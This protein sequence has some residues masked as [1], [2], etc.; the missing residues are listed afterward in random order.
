MHI[1]SRGGGGFEK[2]NDCCVREIRLVWETQFV[3][4]GMVHA[5]VSVCSTGRMIQKNINI[6]RSPTCMSLSQEWRGDWGD[7]SMLW[8]RRRR[9]RLGLVK[10]DQ[11]N[12][13]WMSFNDF[14]VAF[15]SLYVCRWYDPRQ[16]TRVGG[17]GVE[18]RKKGERKKRGDRDR[19]RGRKRWRN[20]LY[21]L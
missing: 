16:D 17:W 6:I 3:R 1:S 18:S 10:N 4:R 14:C 19:D 15:R 11:D 7:N 21:L 20:G 13:F 5:I 2:E 8:T 9:A 12:A